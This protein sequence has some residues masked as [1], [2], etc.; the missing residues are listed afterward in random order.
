S[1]ALKTTSS[2]I[3]DLSFISNTDIAVST[4]K[5][6]DAINNFKEEQYG[7]Q[8][9]M[10]IDIIYKDIM[11]YEFNQK[12][13]SNLEMFFKVCG[14]LEFIDIA[15]LQTKISN[16]KTMKLDVDNYMDFLKSERS[17]E[18]FNEVYDITIENILKSLEESITEL[19]TYF[20]EKTYKIASNK[21]NISLSSSDCYESNIFKEIYFQVLNKIKNK[22]ITTICKVGDFNYLI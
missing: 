9:I 18:I 12:F 10:D 8:T 3:I 6:I 14:L 22:N 2:A 15:S 20:N 11:I 13:I 7:E 5:I 16:E 4:L 21:V 17:R 19:L 1:Y